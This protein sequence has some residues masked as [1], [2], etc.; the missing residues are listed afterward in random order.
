MITEHRG[1]DPMIM[2]SACCGACVQRPTSSRKLLELDLISN[3]IIPAKLPALDKQ[4]AGTYAN[5]E[6]WSHIKTLHAS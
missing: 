4:H 5:Y 3:W 1:L 2:L 6:K